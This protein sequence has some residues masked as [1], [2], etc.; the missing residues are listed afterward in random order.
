M[1]SRQIV[2]VRKSSEINNLD[3]LNGKTIAVMSSTKP[4]ELLLEEDNDNLPKV[5]RLYS[6]ENMDIVFAML[7]NGYVDAAA[8]HEVVAAEYINEFPEYY[9]ILDESLL[10]AKVGVAFGKDADKEFV[11]ELT[12]TLEKMRIDGTTKE[13]L[14]KYGIDADKAL[15]VKEFE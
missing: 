4:E 9:K 10:D 1:N 13:I 2:V 14:Q 11:D 15:E 7:R 5:E 8:C 3:D 6:A 12:R